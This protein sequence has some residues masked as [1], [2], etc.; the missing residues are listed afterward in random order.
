MTAPDQRHIDAV[1]AE[2]AKLNDAHG[3]DPGDCAAG[4]HRRSADGGVDECGRRARN[5]VYDWPGM[6]LVA[7][8]GRS[9]VA[10][11]RAAQGK[12]RC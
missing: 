12:C 3:S 7:V 8:T 6:L 4:G 5:V 11:R 2:L 1:I 9:V 10:Q